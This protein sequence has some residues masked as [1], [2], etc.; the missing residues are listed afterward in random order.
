MN[1]SLFVFIEGLEL[2]TT[3]YSPSNKMIVIM[4]YNGIFFA[5]GTCLIQPYNFRLFSY[6]MPTSLKKSPIR[7]LF[8]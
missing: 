1:I 2:V 3:S 8:P 5:R 7:L 4:Q 6:K